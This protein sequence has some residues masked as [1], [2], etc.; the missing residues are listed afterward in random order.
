M[1]EKEAREKER[2]KRTSGGEGDDDEIPSLSLHRLRPRSDSINAPIDDVC[3][4]YVVDRRSHC[5]IV[6]ATKPPLWLFPRF[7]EIA[8]ACYDSSSEKRAEEEEGDIFN[9][10]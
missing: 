8:A 6:A 7:S 10:A 1:G 2:R 5:C 3:C 4:S 9:T